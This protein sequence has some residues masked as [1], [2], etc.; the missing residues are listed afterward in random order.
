MIISKSIYVAANGSISFFLTEW[1]SI[2]YIY[3][4]FIIHFSVDGHLGCFHVLVTVIS[5][6]N[7]G[8]HLSFR[9]TVFS[10]YM[11]KRGTARSYSING[12]SLMAQRAKK[13]PA[14]WEGWVL[15]ELLS[16]WHSGKESSAGEYVWSLGQE[17]SLEKEIAIHSTILAWEIP[18]TEEPDDGVTKSWTQ[19]GDWTWV[20]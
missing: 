17:D 7:I 9:I 15:E 16:R 18:W 13:L 11:P 6:V 2:V 14:M 19:S 8:V 3:H 1:Y 4:I 10:R 12:A 5:A 20:K